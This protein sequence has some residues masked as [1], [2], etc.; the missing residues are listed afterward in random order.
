MIRPMLFDTHAH[1][2]GIGPETEWPGVIQRAQN[3]GVT[4]ILAV[5]GS[6]AA[7][8]AAVAASRA[9][10][11]TVR[12][13]VGLDRDQAG[14]PPG[15]ASAC[16]VLRATVQHL[17]A[18]GVPVAALGEMGLDFHYS[19]RAARPQIELLREQLRL[20]LE[21]RLPVIVHSR[22]ADQATLEALAGHAAAWSG[23]PGRIGV[24]HCFTGS[25]PFARSLLDLGF[26]ISF[27]GIVTFR[28]A[29]PLRE[30]A[31]AVPEDRLLIETDTP[32]LAPVPQRGRRNEPAFLPH[33]A[34]ELATVRRCAV[35]HIAEVTTANAS[36]LFGWPG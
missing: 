15:P 13:A 12:I 10:P 9:A 7:N 19:P 11:Q 8:A 16:D 34:Q 4:R 17:R 35:E 14:L 36:R 31:A 3:A 2:D 6:P 30:V 23:E 32:Y 18:Q 29:A 26:C 25:G 24:L 5:G 21:L 22:E 20:A 28:N 27:S 33:V 1:F